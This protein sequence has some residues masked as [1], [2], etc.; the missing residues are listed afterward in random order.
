M[1]RFKAIIIE[2]DHA[3]ASKI[4]EFIEDDEIFEL[5]CIELDS[6]LALSKV[7]ALKP[8]IIFMGIEMP[9]YTGFE[10]MQILKQRNINSLIVLTAPS[11]IYGIKAIKAG[12]FD[13]FIKPVKED[14]FIACK[15]RLIK[16]EEI[17]FQQFSNREQNIIHE[18]RLG[19][20]IKEISSSLC[21]APDTVNYHKNRIFRKT[22]VKTTCE[23]L[24]L[25]SND[26]L[27]PSL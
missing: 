27:I 7:P 3:T 17:K 14:D 9:H 11:D 15:K 2:T 21:I 12:A 18:I 6:R 25:I 1:F 19:K 13:Y 8:D 23:L 16:F 22:G 4:A 20:N 5:L 26:Y 10:I 24:H